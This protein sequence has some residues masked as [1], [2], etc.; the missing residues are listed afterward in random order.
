MSLIITKIKVNRNVKAVYN[1]KVIIANVKK[2]TVAQD[3][4][5]VSRDVF[6]VQPSVNVHRIVNVN[7]KRKN[8]KKDHKQMS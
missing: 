8:N 3:A 7:A 1:T 6:N 4:V 2:V 5:D